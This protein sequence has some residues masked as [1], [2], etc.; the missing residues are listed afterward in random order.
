MAS[1]RSRVTGDDG[2]GVQAM[3]TDM[4]DSADV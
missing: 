4:Q 1:G 2:G 3:R